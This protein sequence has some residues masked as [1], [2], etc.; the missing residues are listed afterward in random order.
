MGSLTFTPKTQKKLTLRYTEQQRH[1]HDISHI[2][3]CFRNF[4]KFVYEVG[5]DANGKYNA[6]LSPVEY[7]EIRLMI[8]FH[9]SVY[10]T[11]ADTYKNNE[12]LSAE[13]FA[14]T[15]KLTN[16]TLVGSA[17]TIYDGI[18]YSA[19]HL[20]TL[21]GLTLTQQLFLDTDL[22]GMGG[23]YE[24]F[25]ENGNNIRKEFA[26][27][28]DLTFLTNRVAF[29]KALLARENI[30]YHPVMQE[31]YEDATRNN[32]EHWLA[33]TETVLDVATLSQG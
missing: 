17:M 14:D 13:F 8:W 32:I 31:L 2:E 23:E 25:L 7:N 26:W 16:K 20:E 6:G 21:D 33:E 29:F 27:V 12:T 4:A 30:F 5:Q 18:L 24:K 28:D 11:E 3:D 1:Y 15:F 19:R 10:E 9:D 22:S